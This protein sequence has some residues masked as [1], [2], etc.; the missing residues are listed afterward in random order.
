MKYFLGDKINELSRITSINL[1]IKLMGRVTPKKINIDEV[2]RI[3]SYD[4][5]P[6][7][8]KRLFLNRFPINYFTK[9][10][11]IFLSIKKVL[12]KIFDFGQ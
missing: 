6:C 12:R 4:I 7:L 1:Y 5:E 10:V 2:V 11:L 3:S 9:K 8:L